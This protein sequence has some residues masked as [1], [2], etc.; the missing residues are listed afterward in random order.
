MLLS[1]QLLLL[2]TLSIRT[3]V[4]AGYYMSSI[5]ECTTSSSDLS[6]VEFVYTDY[7]NKAPHLQFNSTV[8]KVVGFSDFGKILADKWN[9]SPVLLELQ[10]EL[11]RFCK[12]N[13]QIDFGTILGKTVLP[14]I[15][16]RSEQEAVAGRSAILMCSAYNFYPRDIN[17][18]WLKNNKKVTTDSIFIEE[19]AN[20]DWTYQVHSH[21]EYKPKSGEK[22]SCVVDHASSMEPIITD[23]DPSLPDSEKG[24]IAAGAAGVVLG[25]VMAVGGFVYYKRKSPGK[26]PVAT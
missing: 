23:W 20:G 6:D 9:D 10:A 17:I 1:L 24:K 12:H 5:A 26:L 2:L 4:I 15:H 3:D 11:D 13:L 25:I 22:I 16:L 21:L 18:Y 19:M 8:G 14:E 7:F